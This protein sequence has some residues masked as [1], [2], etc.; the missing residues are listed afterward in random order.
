MKT[1][2]W[3]EFQKCLISLMVA[4]THLSGAEIGTEVKTKSNAGG[5]ATTITDGLDGRG[6]GAEVVPEMEAIDPQRSI[7]YLRQGD[8]EVA[9]GPTR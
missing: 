7:L 3:F 1:F 6:S 5:I 8:K 4:I 2:G 9:L